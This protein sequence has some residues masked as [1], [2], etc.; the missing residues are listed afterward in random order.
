MYSFSSVSLTAAVQSSCVGQTSKLREVV[1]KMQGDRDVVDVDA[2][3]DA[4]DSDCGRTMRDG[5][6]VA[7]WST[8]CCRTGGGGAQSRAPHDDPLRGSPSQAAA[9]PLDLLT[10]G[11]VIVDD[12]VATDVVISSSSASSSG[13][14]LRPLNLTVLLVDVG[15]W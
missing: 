6:D 7:A 10:V 12:D 5:V 3:A 11:R 14:V 4:A 15:Y 1:T 8:R 9:L 2:A 13:V